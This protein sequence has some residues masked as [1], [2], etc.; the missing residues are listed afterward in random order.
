VSGLVRSL[1]FNWAEQQRQGG[2]WP[3]VARLVASE[4]AET[5]RAIFSLYFALGS[6]GALIAELDRRGVRTKAVKPG[7][8]ESPPKPFIIGS[9]T[10]TIAATAMAASTALPP[11][12]RTCSPT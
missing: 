12:F 6:M 3:K 4:E 7:M 9:V 11:S 10:F 1:S 5:V 2:A 8:K